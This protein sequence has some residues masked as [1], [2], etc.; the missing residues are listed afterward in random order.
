ASRVIATVL[1]RMRC[2]AD[3]SPLEYH[4]HGAIRFASCPQCHGLWFDRER[5]LSSSARDQSFAPPT[6]GDPSLAFTAAR[7]GGAIRRC[8]KCGE[9]LRPKF[10]AEIELDVC[11]RCHGFWLDSGEF[12]AIRGWYARQGRRPGESIAR[13]VHTA[14]VPD[15]IDAVSLVGEFFVSGAAEAVF[16]F[17]GSLL[18]GLF[19]NLFDC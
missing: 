16:S 1:A 14:G 6:P 15:A 12:E 2:P 17:V 3:A 5:Q 11:G 4:Q 9:R 13:P 19:D 10:I 8:G 7:P 18:E